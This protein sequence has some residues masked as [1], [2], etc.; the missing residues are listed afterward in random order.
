ME[1]IDTCKAELDN[2][3][4]TREQVRNRSTL[5]T[6]E[7]AARNR[8]ITETITKCRRNS[9]EQMLNNSSP[10]G[11]ATKYLKSGNGRKSAY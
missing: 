10:L 6:R 5:T 7:Q 9:R 2:Y 3:R 4:N 11:T 1:T 8:K